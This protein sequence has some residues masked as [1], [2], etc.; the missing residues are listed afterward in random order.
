VGSLLFEQAKSQQAKSQQGKSQQERLL[1][2]ER[3]LATQ[4]LFDDERLLRSHTTAIC[5]LFHERLLAT[6]QLFA[7]YLIMSACYV[8]TQQLFI[9][10]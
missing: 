3:L 9:A 1:F 7:C 4:Q 10:I 5:L 8:A 2:H 6:Q